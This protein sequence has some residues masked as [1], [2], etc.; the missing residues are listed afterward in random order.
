M[1]CK[2]NSEDIQKILDFSS[3]TDK[4]KIDTLLRIDC[5]MY[6]NLGTDSTEGERKKTKTLSIKIYR[7]IKKINPI[8]GD[9]LLKTIDL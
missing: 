9:S 3:W 1:D 2:Y 5:N 7:A 6:T 4:K 8:E